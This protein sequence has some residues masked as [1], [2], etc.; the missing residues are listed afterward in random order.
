MFQRSA[1]L[2][3]YGDTKT[4]SFEMLFSMLWNHDLFSIRSRVTDGSYSPELDNCTPTSSRQFLRR[5]F[6]IP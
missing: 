1:G 4:W 5:R 3:E 2:S 6:R